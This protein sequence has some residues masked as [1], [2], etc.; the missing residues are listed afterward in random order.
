MLG[1]VAA[2]SPA[3]NTPSTGRCAGF[4]VLAGQGTPMLVLPLDPVYQRNVL[5]LKYSESEAV[6][7]G[8]LATTGIAGRGT[9]SVLGVFRLTTV[10]GPGLHPI[11]A[12]FVSGLMSMPLA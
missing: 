2:V 4:T 7:C 1:V 5:L 9:A 12:W 10:C 3:W 6:S 8:K 11:K